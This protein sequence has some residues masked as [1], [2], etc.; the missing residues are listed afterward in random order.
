MVLSSLLL[1]NFPEFAVIHTVKAFGVVNEEVDVFLELSC[2]FDDPADVLG[3]CCCTDFSLVV[4]VGGCSLVAVVSHSGG[5]PC[6]E[7]GL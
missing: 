6:V 7:R 5:F 3:L 2:F 1:K 4:A